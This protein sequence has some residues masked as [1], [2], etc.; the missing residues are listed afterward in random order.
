MAQMLADRLAEYAGQLRFEDLPPPV[1]HEAKRRFIDS[2]ATAV[3]AM[4]ADAYAMNLSRSRLHKVPESP[5]SGRIGCGAARS[6]SRLWLPS[7][8]R[9]T[10]GR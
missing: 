2:F 10:G 1:V 7:L 6:R 3:G 9:P 8:R 4:D 5:V